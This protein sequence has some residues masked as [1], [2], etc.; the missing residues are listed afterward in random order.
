MK[1]GKIRI[2]DGN[3]VFTRHMMVNHLPCRDILWVYKR[4]EGVS[5][6]E[7]KQISTSYLVVVTR[8]KK[9]YKFDMTDKEI[10]DCIQLLSALNPGIVVGFPKGGRIQLQ[11]LPNTRDL[12]ALVTEDGRH[13]LPRR[14]LRSG[15]LYHISLTDQDVLTEEYRL[16]EVIDLRTKQEI[17]EKP[18]TVMEGVTYHENPII[19]EETLG[20]SQEGLSR[21]ANLLKLMQNRNM[22]PE[23]FIESQYRN[24]VTDQ[25]SVKQ[26]ARFMDILLHHEE[27]AIL[28]HC[29]AGKDRVGVGTALLLSALGVPRE[30]I[31]EDFLKT[32]LYLEEEMQHMVRYLETKTIVDSK[33][34][35]KIRILY[36]VKGEYLDTVFETIDQE[37]G[38]IDYFMKKAL[39]LNPRAVDTLKNKYLV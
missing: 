33:V 24:F 29:S 32:N 23:E 19:D 30:V 11:S 26:Y 20:I 5:G 17:L 22:I 2:E 21:S 28:W 14:L 1:Y 7:Q 25:Y 10:H 37:Y 4:Q 16:T 3:L 15:S 12:G 35:D 36:K 27:G 39:Y 6:G 34:M 31:R 9:R 18:D 8:R 38:S 13:I